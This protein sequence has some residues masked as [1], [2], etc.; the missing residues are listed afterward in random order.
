MALISVSLP[1][2]EKAD[3]IVGLVTHDMDQYSNVVYVKW[4]EPKAPNGLIILYDVIY[5]R[6]GDSEVAGTP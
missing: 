1:P 3:D 2:T 5:K 4:E 6:L